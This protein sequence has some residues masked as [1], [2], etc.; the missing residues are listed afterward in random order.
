M[1]NSSLR[2]QQHTIISDS[3]FTILMTVPHEIRARGSAA[4]LAYNYALLEGKVKVCRARL[5]II[6]Q[7]RTGKTS[8]KKSLIGLPFNPEE[9]STEVLE[10]NSSKLE[11]NVEQVVEWKAVSDDS[12]AEQVRPR[13]LSIAR[14]IAE[15]MMQ[16]K[17]TNEG[18]ISPGK[19]KEMDY[20]KKD[21]A[22]PAEVCCFY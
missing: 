15:N 21:V 22:G 19:E 20:E 3:V 10:M 8:L 12:E 6:G 11:V 5:L 17:E 1:R 7:D 13:N 4:E 14:L 9:P 2:H 16:K 18:Q